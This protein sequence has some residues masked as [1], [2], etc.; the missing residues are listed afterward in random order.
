MTL[1]E[2]YFVMILGLDNAGKTTLLER[3]K[4]IYMK[5]G[6]SASQI[7]PTVG[8]NVGKVELNGIK[9]NFWDLGGQ[10]SLQAI[11]EK[12]YNDCH[13]IIFV[14]DSTDKERIEECKKTMEKVFT[15]EIIEGF[16]D[17]LIQAYL[18]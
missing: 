15:S 14:V 11:W 1:K 8:L 4:M 6:L 13:G 16:D 10:K 5:K 7:G 18:F 12:Y 2:Q 17:D 9:V 3:V